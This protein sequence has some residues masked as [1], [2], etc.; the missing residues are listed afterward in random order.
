V[1]CA[2][3][4]KSLPSCFRGFH[5]CSGQHVAT[6]IQAASHVAIVKDAVLWRLE[7]GERSFT[8][9]GPFFG[10]ISCP[11]RPLLK[12]RRVCELWGPFLEEQ[13]YGDRLRSLEHP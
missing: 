13:G 9:E 5:Y 7:T 12:L 2:V 1:R 6:V 11:G 10:A 4:M 8:F 3:I